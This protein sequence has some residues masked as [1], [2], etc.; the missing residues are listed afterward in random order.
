MPS[1]GPTG[2]AALAA[3]RAHAMPAPVDRA[4]VQ[5]FVGCYEH[6]V[7]KDVTVTLR[8]DTLILDTGELSTELRARVSEAA[9]PA[10][11]AMYDPPLSLLP[12]TVAFENGA[13]GRQR[14]ILKTPGIAGPT[15]N[16]QQ[17]V[18]EPT[19]AAPHESDAATGALG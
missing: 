7:L 15:S 17:H 2:C 4:A 5:A 1:C 18:F 13:D 16:E 9:S 14:L 6:P 10:E 8:A 12:T 11:Y 19:L 3:G